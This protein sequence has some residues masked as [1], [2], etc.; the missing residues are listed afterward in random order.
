MKFVL[1]YAHNT[2]SYAVPQIHLMPGNSRSFPHAF[3]Q[4]RGPT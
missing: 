2:R 3:L 4:S 1:D